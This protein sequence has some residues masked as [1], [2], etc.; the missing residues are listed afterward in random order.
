MEYT[1]YCPNCDQELNT[2]HAMEA[3]PLI[4]CTCGTPME[5]KISGNGFNYSENN[6]RR[7]YSAQKIIG[8]QKR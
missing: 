1:Y 8:G 3:K 7:D 2:I 5:K 6:W 4:Q